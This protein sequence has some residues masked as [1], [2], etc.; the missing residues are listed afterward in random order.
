MRFER[1][2]TL[3]VLRLSRLQPLRFENPSHRLGLSIDRV[4]D[5]PAGRK[6]LRL[7]LREITGEQAEQR[8]ATRRQISGRVRRQHARKPEAHFRDDGLASRPGG[9]RGRLLIESK[10]TP[11]EA[12]E[13]LSVSLRPPEQEERT[14]RAR[15]KLVSV[16]LVFRT[17]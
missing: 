7:E 8:E 3:R 16:R 11:I 4:G 2:K 5:G 10:R 17:R 15:A 9:R 12:R 6:F 14:E 13:E 1:R